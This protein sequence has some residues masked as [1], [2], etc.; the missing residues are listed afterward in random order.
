MI[1][2]FVLLHWQ[3]LFAQTIK[4]TNTESA[5]EHL[6][7]LFELFPADGALL[8]HVVLELV[9]SVTLCAEHEVLAGLDHDG[10]ARIHANA[11][12]H[13]FWDVFDTCAVHNLCL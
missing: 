2:I 11:T 5:K 9:V 1:D 3:K 12:D 8:T 7:R 4:N 6:K 10:L 13:V